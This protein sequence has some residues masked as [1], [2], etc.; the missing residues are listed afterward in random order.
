MKN[1]PENNAEHGRDIICEYSEVLDMI[2]NLKFKKKFFG[3]VD[4]ADVWKKIY[5]LNRLYEKLIIAEL[6]RKCPAQ[7]GNDD[8][9]AD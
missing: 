4:E 3:G 6:S 1:K 7:R 2:K 5:E 9:A 8:E